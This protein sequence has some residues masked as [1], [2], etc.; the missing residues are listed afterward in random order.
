MRFMLIEELDTLGN[1]LSNQQERYFNNSK[2]KNGSELKVF[3]NSGSRENRDIYNCDSYPYFFSESEVYSKEYGD[4]TYLVYLNITNPFS[5]IGEK[6][7]DLIFKEFVPYCEKNNIE[8]LSI[9]EVKKGS[10][11]P[12]PLVDTLYHYLRE[13]TNYD[14][15]LIEEFGKN[16]SYFKKFGIKGQ[17]SYTPFRS[18]QIKLISNKKPTSSDYINR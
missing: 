3:Y 14:G 2:M 18:N 7:Y 1:E 17:I 12:F 6:E 16:A 11:V 15:I 4:I 9:N 13:Y 10:Y 5:V 8:Y